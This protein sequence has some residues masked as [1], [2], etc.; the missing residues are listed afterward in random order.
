MRMMP[1]R[2]VPDGCGKAKSIWPKAMGRFGTVP[3]E[4]TTYDDLRTRITRLMNSLERSPV[5]GICGHGGAGKSTLAARLMI[6]L[7]GESEQVVSTD[8]FYAVDAGPHSGLFDLHDWSALFDL[9]HGVRVSPSPQRL[10]Y[11]VRTY[12]GA[13]RTYEAP[14]PPVVIVEGIRLLRPESMPLMDLAVWIDMSPGSAG[15][16]AIERNRSQGD[17]SAELDLW[18][19]KWIPEAHAYAQAMSPE[20]LAH[21][22][23]DGARPYLSHR[24][25]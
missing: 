10:V 8:R 12:D 11:P 4:T 2:R 22:I 3:H 19:T 15:S 16:R 9:L 21:V 6:D 13:E 24:R 23:L 7:G 18:R 25:A 20:L 5:V 1:M 17:S 14:M